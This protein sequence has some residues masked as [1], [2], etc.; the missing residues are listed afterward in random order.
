MK[1]TFHWLE[2]SKISI[3]STTQA[4]FTRAIPNKVGKATLRVVSPHH[5][6]CQKLILEPSPTI[7]KVN[8]EK[9]YQHYLMFFHT[10][11]LK[12]PVSSREHYLPHRL[13]YLESTT[14]LHLASLS[15][16]KCHSHFPSRAR[17]NALK[18][19]IPTLPQKLESR[20]CPS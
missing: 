5:K 13:L 2:P 8:L 18:F 12:A 20:P 19:L 14:T 9:E 1:L 15:D 10:P 7:N 6:S 17:L 16:P 3:L 11:T 4:S